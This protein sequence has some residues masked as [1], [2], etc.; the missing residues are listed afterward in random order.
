MK[1]VALNLALVLTLLG[2]A[3]AFAYHDHRPVRCWS[4]TSV[5]GITRTTC[6]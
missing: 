1:T 3:P 4:S 2:I 5:T 6:R